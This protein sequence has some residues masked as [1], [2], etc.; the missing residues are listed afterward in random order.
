MA[1]SRR[2]PVV[3]FSICRPFSRT[4]SFT[5]LRRFYVPARFKSPDVCRIVAITD[6]LQLESPVF[7]HL[8]VHAP[9]L[10]FTHGGEGYM[11]LIHSQ[12]AG[13]RNSYMTLDSYTSTKGDCE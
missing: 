6:G 4:W 12:R 1:I 2:P 7:V 13:T 3:P 5:E 11:K 9:N 8:A 10:V